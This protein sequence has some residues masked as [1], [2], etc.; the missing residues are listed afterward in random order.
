MALIAVGIIGI[1]VLIIVYLD[2]DKSWPFLVFGGGSFFALWFSLLF[3][4]E[5]VSGNEFKGGAGPV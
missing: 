5:A 3:I 4:Y 1:A 2:D